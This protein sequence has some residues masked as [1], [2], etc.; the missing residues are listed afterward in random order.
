MAAQQAAAAQRAGVVWAHRGRPTK[1]VIVR[2]TSI[3]SV[4]GGSLVQRV[5]RNGRTVSLAALDAAIPSSW[6]T[7]EG[8]TARLERGCGAH[9][10]TLLDVEGVKTLQL[11]GGAD[12]ADAAI[13]Y[14]G[15]GRIQLRGVTVTSVDP[16]SGQPVGPD[17]GGPPLHRRRGLGRLDATDATIS[18]LGTN[19][20]GDNHG[21]PALCVRPWQHRLADRHHACCA[22]PPGSCSPGPR[23]CGCRT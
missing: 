2:A 17:C 9:P 19:P 23:A 21:Q 11:A 16:A 20:V 10:G 18:D 7:I 4:A 13:L 5:A 8:D 15:S 22:T 6:M 3:D 1:L 14:T 12:A